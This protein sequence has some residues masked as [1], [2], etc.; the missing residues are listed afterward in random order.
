MRKLTAALFALFLAT[1][2][3]AAELT[4]TID[5]TFDVRP[6]ATVRVG[7]TNGKIE[8][9]SWDQPRVRVVAQKQ[10]KGDREDLKRALAELKVELQPRDG[11]LVVNTQHPREGA[12][13]IFDWF[14]GDRIQAQVSYTISVPRTMNVE[15]DNTNG[16]VLLTGVTGLHELETTNGRITVTRCAGGLDATTTN[17]SISAE[18][19]SVAKGASLDFTTTNGKIVVA[20][21][22]NIGVDVDAETTNGSIESQLPVSTRTVDRN[23]LRGQINGGGTRLRL[24]TTNGA[25]D[26]NAL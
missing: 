18:L 11:G 9:A 15:V 17:G 13:T 22:R 14:T 1:A 10:V 5:R 3:S 19:T 25:I 4:E 20:L 8:I 23:E 12:S 26:I 21:P 6:G 16:A 7:N 2:A 24:R